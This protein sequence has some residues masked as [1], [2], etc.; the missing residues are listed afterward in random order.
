MQIGKISSGYS[1]MVLKINKLPCLYS[2]AIGLTENNF[3][4]CVSLNKTFPKDAR[5]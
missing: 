2:T 5:G 4:F 3:F 1:Y